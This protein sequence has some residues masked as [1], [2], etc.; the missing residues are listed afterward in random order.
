MALLFQLRGQHF[1][2]LFGIHAAGGQVLQLGLG[3]VLALLPTAAICS[4]SC[5]MRCSTRWRPSTT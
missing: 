2:L 4:A 5:C 1:G 3:I